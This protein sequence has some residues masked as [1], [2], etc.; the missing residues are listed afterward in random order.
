M[1]PAVV[2][3]PCSSWMR[4]RTGCAGWRCEQNVDVVPEPD[5]LRALPDVEAHLRRPLPGVAAVD[6]EDGVLDRRARTAAAASAADRRSTISAQR[7]RTLTLGQLHL[8]ARRAARPD[9]DAA[10]VRALHRERRGHAGF[11]E[12]LDQKQPRASLDELRLGGALLDLHAALRV[13]VDASE[14]V[15]VEHL[16]QP[17]DRHALV[18]QADRLV[19]GLGDPPPS[20][21]GRD[22]ATRFRFGVPAAPAAEVARPLPARD[23]AVAVRR[24]SERIRWRP[25]PSGPLWGAVQATSWWSLFYRRS[26]RGASRGRF[27]CRASSRT[28]IVG[29]LYDVIRHMK[30]TTIFID[31][32]LEREL[33]ALARR[34]GQ[35]VAALVREAVAQYV[36]AAR[37]DR[38]TRLGFVATGR[39]GRTDTARRH[40]ELLFQDVATP[41]PRVAKG[42]RRRAASRRTASR[43]G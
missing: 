3:R 32:R 21:A 25:P 18:G 29:S 5:V 12:H 26:S 9:V 10:G 7:S 37:D 33:Q 17:I 39:S 8:R 41:A 20:A 4:T 11:V 28:K 31:E 36:V 15:A 2:G 38:P 22:S 34:Q 43:S 13:D 6:L 24:A 19:D 27:F 42:R 35:P 40:E 30:R 16:L 23:A 1:N 14:D